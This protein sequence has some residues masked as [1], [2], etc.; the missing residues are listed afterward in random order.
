[1]DFRIL[2]P[3]EAFD[4]DRAITLGGTRQRALLA[5]LLLNAPRV[6]STDRLIDELWP[7]E[8][9]AEKALQVAVSRLRKS[10]GHELIVTR[11]PGYELRVG[12]EDLD[13]GR[14][15]ALAA[16]GR[17]AL[18]AGNPALASEKLDAALAQWRGPA[19]ADLAHEAF[20][21]TEIARLEDLR[22]SAQEDRIAA[23]LE[24]GHEAELVP[25]LRELIDR[26]PL[27]ERLRGQLML[28]LYRSG[29]QA[30]ALDAYAHART[31]LV[32]QLGIEPGRELRELHEAILRQEPQLDRAVAAPA[33]ETARG[34]F[35][36]R[37][38]DLEQLEAALE[39]A[40]HG[41]G[42]VALVVGEPGV[43]KSRLSE[44]LI[45]KA[46]A[47]G[48][49]VLTGRCWEAGGAP[50]YWPWVQVMRS[51]RPGSEAVL[52]P[53]EATAPG[54]NPESARFR[55]FEEVVARLIEAAREEPL[56]LV[57]DDLHAADEPSLLLLQ[58]VARAIR[59]SRLLIVCAFRDVDPTFSVPLNAAVA[60]LAREP[61]VS[62]ISLTGLSEPAVAEYVELATGA[63]ATPGSV[64]AIHGRTAGNPL[65]VE[66]VVS[67]SEA[68][69]GLDASLSIPP[70]IRSVI[71]RRVGRLAPGCRELLGRASVF[72]REFRADA[73]AQLCA[74]SPAGLLDTLDEAMVQRVVEEV[75][76]APG[77]LRFGHV[78]IRD[79]LYEELTPAR[80]LQL[81]RDAGAV[82]ED[83]YA[84]DLE[85][86]LAELS[87]H[88]VTAAPAG[89]ADKAADYA[90]R[91]GVRAVGQLAYEEAVR[92]FAAALTL[93]TDEAER[94][95]L[96]LMLG[97][98]QARA[99]DA[100]AAQ[101][102]T[103]AA[104]LAD[105][106]GLRDQLAEAALGYGGRVL[107]E[108]TRGDDRHMRL[109]ERAAEAVGE[110][111]SA[112]RVRLLARLAGGPL[113]DSRFPA[114][115]RHAAERRGAGNGPPPGGPRQRSPT[116]SRATSPPTIHR[117]FPRDRS[118]WVR[119]WC[120]PPPTAGTS[121][122]RWRVT[123]PR[124]WR[125]SSSA[126]IDA[127]K[128]A[129]A[130]MAELAGEIRQPA[131]TWLME[132]YRALFALLEGEL[133]EAERAMT[134]ARRAGATAHPWN[135]AV[136]HGL[137]LYLLR[138]EQGRLEEVVGP[139]RRFVAENP[140]YPIFGCV[141]AQTLAELGDLD[142]AGEA[143]E[144]VGPLPFDEELLVSACLLMRSRRGALGH[145]ALGAALRPACSPTGTGWPS[146]IR[147][148]A[149]AAVARYLGIAA[150]RARALKTTPSATSRGIG[151]QR[152]I[153]ARPWL[154]RTRAEWAAHTAVGLAAWRPSS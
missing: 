119:S 68:E 29:R 46:R 97:E 34:T 108:V 48:V 142:A 107:W 136:T 79:T 49:T 101:T 17:T 75:P 149:S 65:F 27:R 128:A 123:R 86:H 91:A 2:G 80:R 129:F 106:L 52:E 116:P 126:Q 40:V 117:P 137:Q 135:A 151:G 110:E 56:V 11:A 124:C 19:L 73:L 133:E 18:A 139:I 109:L 85:S 58:F 87:H 57:L 60:E 122:A 114:E 144:D 16:E 63:P 125:T 32:E 95:E 51:H 66:E 50:A 59:D 30:E 130:A 67:L 64:K 153:G 6:V 103:E 5:M 44:E 25:E 12:A 90:R 152:A 71:G 141:L 20:C 127:A 54:A 13:L 138:R 150:S 1:M 111:D 3:L 154:E 105:R 35:V 99:G 70:G 132:V 112:L 69:G 84:A 93:V 74:V 96:L 120:R 113:R 77:R 72:G 14:F 121:S 38:R 102:F 22:D 146:A 45:A 147:R 7:G 62:H 33:S 143:V 23:R 78:L 53:S 89:T 21:Q 31:E 36:G 42:R 92:H 28:A 8:R 37:G 115:R 83:V 61:H 10:L 131:Q 140:G 82:L 41:R 81:H 88:F 145:R 148:S 15:E 55:L 47:D 4:G 104:K 9:G 76:G 24:L 39:S 94:C 43:G 26:H 118:R 98:A 100:E 134:A